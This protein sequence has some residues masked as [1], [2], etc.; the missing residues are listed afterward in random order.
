MDAA[1]L[2]GRLLLIGLFLFSGA[3]KLMDLPGTAGAIASKGLPAP[4]V[5]AAIAGA[6]EVIGA[7]LIA[8]GWNTRIG[9]LALIGYTIV[10]TYFFHNFWD[11]AGPER[12]SNMIAFNKNLGLIGGFL[13][14]L[15]FGP[16]RY[17][18]DGGREPLRSY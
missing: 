6:V 18:V 3:G 11:M 16:G 14:L 12:M 9:A 7:V 2:L 5:L 10:A 1:I 17:A 4:M 15:G 13:L 8:I